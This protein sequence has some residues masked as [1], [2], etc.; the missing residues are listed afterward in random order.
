[1]Q[2]MTDDMVQQILQ[3]G[4]Q[5]NHQKLVK[6]IEMK[7]QKLIKKIEM[8]HE[9]PK[10]YNQEKRRTETIVLGAALHHNIPYHSSCQCSVT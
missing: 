7:H 6:K 1:M 2:K 5:M 4:T 8:K 3:G 9:G 10:Q